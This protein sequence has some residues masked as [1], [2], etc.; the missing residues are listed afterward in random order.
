MG[1]AII[2]LI[3]LAV[4]FPG[5]LWGFFYGVIISFVLLAGYLIIDNTL[6]GG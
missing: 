1:Q 3:L 6:G 4:F 5:V 2:I